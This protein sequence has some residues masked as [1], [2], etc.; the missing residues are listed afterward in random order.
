MSNTKDFGAALSKNGKWP[1]CRGECRRERGATLAAL[2][3]AAA[4]K[5]PPRFD[6]A[7]RFPTHG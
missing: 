6:R 3:A 7:K 1:G 2:K 4:E 5:D